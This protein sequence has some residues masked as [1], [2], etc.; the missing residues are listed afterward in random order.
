MLHMKVVKK[1]N[2]KSSHHKE[3]KFFF[4]FYSVYDDECSLNIL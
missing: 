1:V 4:F 3:E 2:A